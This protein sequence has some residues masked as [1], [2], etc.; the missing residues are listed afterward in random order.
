[1][2]STTSAAMQP[3]SPIAAYCI[4]ERPALPSPSTTEAFA[5]LTAPKRRSPAHTSSATSGGLVSAI[6]SASARGGGVRRLSLVR[7]AAG[8]PLERQPSGRQQHERVGQE[9]AERA[10]GT[11]RLGRF[12]DRLAQRTN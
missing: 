7:G 12:V 10:V 11:P 1:M 9:V 2:M 4:G 5:A 3:A 8:Q 6:R